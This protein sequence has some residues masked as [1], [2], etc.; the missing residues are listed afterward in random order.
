MFIFLQT[1]NQN[2]VDGANPNFKVDILNA[3]I[4]E[5]ASDSSAALA[6]VATTLRSISTPRRAPTLRGRRG[7][8]NTMLLAPSPIPDGAISSNPQASISSTSLPQS[9]ETAS[10]PFSATSSV[11]Q[12][13]TQTAPPFKLAH[14]STLAADESA[15][16]DTHSIKSARS[17]SSSVMSSTNATKHAEMHDP[18]LN[19]SVVE[20]VS[21]WF[22]PE[23]A[24]TRAVQTGEVA[25][26]YNAPLEH[27]VEAS[28]S[29]IQDT[30]DD[31][32]IRFDGFSSLEKVAPNPHFI[33]ALPAK[34]EGVYNVHF[35]R[36]AGATGHTGRM[37]VAFKYQVHL[38][39]SKSAGEQVPVSVSMASKVDAERNQTLVKLGYGLNEQFKFSTAESVAITG[40]MIIL[41]IDPTSTGKIVQC[42]A[43]N[44]GLFVRDKGL[45][46]W[47]L[48]DVT[49]PLHGDDAAK[50][51][52]Q[53]LL[54][55]FAT[56]GEVKPGNVESRWEIVGERL[57]GGTG[58]G[59][60]LSKLVES[61]APGAVE[62]DPFADED[63]QNE[64]LEASGAGKKNEEWVPLKDA[65][66]LKSGTYLLN[67]GGATST[68]PVV[69][70]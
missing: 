57:P 37:A 48:G 58:S 29:P 67:N 44:G 6:S 50:K 63:A 7:D 49:L 53:E 13:A 55:R 10:A 45:V 68:S 52:E 15:A 2:S 4:Q 47:R 12:S 64:Q 38:D 66:R 46:Y 23:G 41:H 56:D 70:A 26:A 18:G 43:N 20:T 21:A 31:A 19:A 42:Q 39:G 33:D 11:P 1:S 36:M 16:S 9:P 59:V 27:H 25:L 61:A 8:R 69:G 65:R 22:T 28:T 54:V 5:E 32:I 17:L 40:L 51:P 30:E 14:R 62:A 60:A 24:V 35:G 34:G 3:P